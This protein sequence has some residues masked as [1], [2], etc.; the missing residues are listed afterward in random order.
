MSTQKKDKQKVLDE[1]WTEDRVRSFLDLSAPE[2]VNTD[3][4]TLYTAYKSMR[5]ENFSDFLGFFKDA[6]RNFSA[7]NEEGETLINLITQ[8]KKSA[9]YASELKKYL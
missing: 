1:V 8:H 7:E 5:L 4:H 6:N 2:G 9:T 3:F